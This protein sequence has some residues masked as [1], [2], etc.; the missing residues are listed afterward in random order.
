[1][2]FK[3]SDIE[4]LQVDHP[5]TFHFGEGDAQKTLE[6]TAHFGLMDDEK[7]ETEAKKGDEPF[8][9]KV[10]KGWDGILDD[11]NKPL[12]FNKRNLDKLIKL[13]WWRTGVIDAFYFCQTTAG[14]KNS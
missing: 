9:R 14:R 7:T 13:S 10:L 6:F 5:V 8:I 1:M 3:I 4:N 2:S 12:A 11:K